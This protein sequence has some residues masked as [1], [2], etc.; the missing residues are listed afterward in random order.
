MTEFKFGL[1]WFLYGFIA[2]YFAHPLWIL[3]TKIVQEAK[4]ARDE[5]HKGPKR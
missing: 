2:G 1:E 3:L 4:L 5:W